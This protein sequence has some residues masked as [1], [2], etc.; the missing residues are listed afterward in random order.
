MADHIPFITGEEGCKIAQLAFSDSRAFRV[1]LWQCPKISSGLDPKKLWVDAGI[2]GLG[3]P[4]ESRVDPWKSFAK[5]FP[6]SQKV[7]DAGFQAK[8]IAGEVQE[9]VNAVLDACKD[10]SP[11]WI[12]IPQLPIAS[13]TR[14]NKINRALASATGKWKSTSKFHGHLILPLVFTHQ[15]QIN[16]KS[17]RNPKVAFAEKCY[18]DSQ[19]DGIWTVDSSL[20]DDSGSSTL[21]ST[22]FPGM[23]RLHEELNDLIASRIRIAGPYWGLNLVLWA[24]GLVD[25]PGIGLGTGYKYFTSGGQL[26][27]PST[28]IA[29]PTLRRRVRHGQQL[30][31]WLDN[32]LSKLGSTHPAFADFT[33]I[34]SRFTSTPTQFVAKRQIA[35]F[36]K[37]WYDSIAVT[38]ASGRP[39]AMFQDLAVAYALGKSLGSFGSD[40]GTAKRPESVAEPLMLS[41]L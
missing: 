1:M 34:K 29:I 26:N 12:T 11:M 14:R 8:P 20:V 35:E 6:H 37:T 32:S 16:L 10:Q 4:T 23:I 41:C 22:R 24:K 17:A 2:D 30:R 25:Y 7:S 5:K 39:M 19:A 13:D 38:P 21:K 36:Y 33:N 15:E 27:A 28:R 40:E 9:F 3:E 31:S 18:Q